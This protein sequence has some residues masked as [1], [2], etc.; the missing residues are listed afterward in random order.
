MRRLVI[1]VISFVL[2][3]AAVIGKVPTAGAETLVLK[4]RWLF[5]GTHASLE[6]PGLV[7]VDGN[8]IVAIGPGAEI[9]PG[10]RTI[11]LGDATL[12]PGFIDAHTHLY[13][14][15]APTTGRRD[16]LDQFKKLIPQQSLERSLLTKKTLHAGFTTCR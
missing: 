3:A 12:C 7:V 13:A 11:D 9:P 5:D 10:A 15:A 16:E 2:T 8:R 6:S 14:R 1:T 4:A